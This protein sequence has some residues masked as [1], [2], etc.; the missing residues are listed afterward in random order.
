MYKMNTIIRTIITTLVIIVTS[1]SLPVRTWNVA[2]VP[3]TLPTFSS[4]R[5]PRIDLPGH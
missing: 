3:P 4:A 1:W 2:R 5:S